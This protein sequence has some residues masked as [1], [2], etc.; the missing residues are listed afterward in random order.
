MEMRTLSIMETF[1][2]A[3]D[4]A[5]ERRE[6]AVLSWADIDISPSDQLFTL[7]ASFAFRSPSEP[8]V[9]LLVMMRATA[10][11]VETL[12]DEGQYQV[13]E[14]QPVGEPIDPLRLPFDTRQAL[15]I[16]MENGGGQFVAQ[17]PDIVWPLSISLRYRDFYYSRGDLVWMGQFGDLASRATEYIYIDALTGELVD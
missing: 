14:P 13:G 15:E 12:C 7:S 1:P 16:V 17:H 9:W 5:R 3:L 2:I 8:P 4:V 10:V 6:D 11:G